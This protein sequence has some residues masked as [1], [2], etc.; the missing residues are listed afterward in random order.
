[1]TPDDLDVPADVVSNIRSVCLR[2]RDAYEE[3]AWV[4][5]RWRVRKRTFAH[6]LVVDA[7][8]PP[9]YARAAGTDGLDDV[10]VLGP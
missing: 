1:M 10:Q 6:V 7:A 9:A 2:L 8:W 5:V 4:G 3:R